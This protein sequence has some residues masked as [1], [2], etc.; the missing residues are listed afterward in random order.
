MLLQCSS[1]EPE[2]GAY[3]QVVCDRINQ[4]N[5]LQAVQA[6]LLSVV[7]ELVLHRIEGLYGNLKGLYGA[8]AKRL[9]LTY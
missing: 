7:Q 5:R 4:R 1:G 3:R 6:H 8:P 2:L 9:R